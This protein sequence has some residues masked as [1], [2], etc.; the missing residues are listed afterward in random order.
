LNAIIAYN[1]TAG[2]GR[3][4]SVFFFKRGEKMSGRRKKHV[5]LQPDT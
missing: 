2:S 5:K 3:T 4:K 1:V